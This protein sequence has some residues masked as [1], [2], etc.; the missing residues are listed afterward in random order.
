MVRDVA[1]LAA[2]GDLEREDFQHVRLLGHRREQDHPDGLPHVV[3]VERPRTAAVDRYRVVV[4]LVVVE[5][6]QLARTRLGLR[7]D[8]G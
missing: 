1:P 5:R 2:L 8:G 6:A 3:L 7:T 4:V